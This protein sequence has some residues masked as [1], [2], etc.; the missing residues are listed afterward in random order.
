MLKLVISTFF[1]KIKNEATSF[2]LN[3]I[4]IMIALSLFIYSMN[5]LLYIFNSFI[6]NTNN[7]IYIEG[8]SNNFEKINNKILLYERYDSIIYIDYRICSEYDLYYRHY[9]NNNLAKIINLNEEYPKIVLS[10]RYEREYLKKGKDTIAINGIIYKIN[11]YID[12]SRSYCNLTGNENLKITGFNIEFS[13]I[14][15]NEKMLKEKTCL[16]EYF[17]GA[18]VFGPSYDRYSYLKEEYIINTNTLFIIMSIVIF[19]VYPY[20]MNLNKDNKVLRLVGIPRRTL[21]VYNI[22]FYLFVYILAGVLSFIINYFVDAEIIKKY[23][24]YTL[25][26]VILLIA[27]N[28]LIIFQKYLLKARG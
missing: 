25:C 9:Y 14:N 5:Q 3:F 2:I 24:S 16:E 26:M 20:L 15:T 6:V 23:L 22:L 28:L 1:N 19:L 27:I 7:I 17:V 12:S 13:D 10:R 18:N 8:V 11:G 4:M 21:L